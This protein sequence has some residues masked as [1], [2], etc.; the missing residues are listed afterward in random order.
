MD[1]GLHG[2]VALVAGASRGLGRAIA[3]EL[4]TEGASLVLCARGEAGLRQACEAIAQTAG[5]PVHGVPAD[6]AKFEDVRG[7]VAAGEGRF[8]GIDVL[9]T[10]SGGPPSGPFDSFDAEAW[11]EAGRLLLASAVEMARAVLPGM[12][13]R[14]WGRIVNVTSVAAKQPI[15]GLVLS[16]SLRAAVIGMA[17]TLADE[18]ATYGITVNNVLPGYT[19]T[20]RLE[21]LARERAAAGSLTVE[22]VL[23]GFERQ[24]PMGRIGEP[25]ELAA[26]V[27]FLASTRA[28]FI[29]GQSIAVDGGF[30]RA[31][32]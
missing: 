16:N 30:V 5:V 22:Q 31:L 26:L 23:A 9:V 19:R 11:Q 12:R 18:V 2:K 17:R 32:L 13:K 15:E 21:Q 8:G 25:P 27:A 4:A 20:E 10:N 6:V 1:L 7:L 14:R 29:T 28:S 3:E 24:I